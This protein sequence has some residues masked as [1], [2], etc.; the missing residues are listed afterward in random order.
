M[1]KL[2]VWKGGTMNRSDKAFIAVVLLLSITLFLSTSRLAKAINAN[3]AVA[4]VTYRDKEV[5]RINMSENG[6]YNLVGDEG[7]MVI[8]VND[9]AIRVK[10]EV[11]PL[12]YCSLQG[13]VSKTRTPIVCLPNRVI[14]EVE[15]MNDVSEEDITIR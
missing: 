1:V 13:W 11:S 15:N 10:E 5:R 4:V 7:P 3:D 14:I 8:E 9:G 6:L 2:G 12:N